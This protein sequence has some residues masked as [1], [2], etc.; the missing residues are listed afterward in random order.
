MALSAGARLGVYEVISLLGVGG[1]GEVYR[2]RDTK[3]HRDVAL[4]ILPTAFT[5]DE[6]RLRRFEQE[7]RTAAGLNHPNICTIYEIGKV[8]ATHFIAMELVEGA[9]LRG[10]LPV[11]GLALKEL[12]RY[13]IQIADGL[14]KAHERGITHRDV[15]PENM[16]FSDDGIIKI[17]DF[18]LA[19]LAESSPAESGEFSTDL[20][21]Q[22]GVLVGTV[23]Y[24]SPEQAQ[25]EP[26]DIRSD[27][28]SLGV[29]LFEF[30][31]G[32]PPYAGH[33]SVD[34]LHAIVHDPIPREELT[35]RSFPD[36]FIRLIEKATEKNRDLRYPSA[37]EIAVDLRRL[38][39]HL[40]TA[41]QIP[42]P[43]KPRRVATYA[44]VAM[45]LIAAGVAAWWVRTRTPPTDVVKPAS[46]E[47]LADTRRLVVLPFENLTRQSTDDWLSGALADSLTFGL[48]SVRS[49]V[50][51]SSGTVAEL[52]RQ[53]SI[54]EAGPLT[55]PVLQ[56]LTS[57]VR[58]RYYVN[59]TYQKVGDQLRV[60]ASLIDTANGTTQAQESVTDTFT[61][62]FNIED[63]LTRRVAT[64]LDPSEK[65]A[66][67]VET[68]SLDAY[69]L[70]SEAR[71]VY[72]ASTRSY[73]EAREK[74]KEVVRL[75][76]QYA[77]GWAL[78]GKV[79][80]RLA[81]PGM[82]TGGALTDL[83][84][85][86]LSAAR[87]AVALNSSLYDAVIAVALASRETGD[88]SGWRQ[89]AE[90]ATRL[91]PRMAEG[92]ALLADSY[93]LN[94][95]WGCRRDLNAVQAEEYYRRTLRIDPRFG[96]AYSNFGFH[97]L[98]ADRPTDALRV[99][100]EGL[101]ILPMYVNL[102]TLRAS[103]LLRLNRVDEAEQVLEP[104]VRLN[105]QS[106]LDVLA[107][108][109]LD[110]HRDHLA[111]ANER[112]NVLLRTRVQANESGLLLAIAAVY[113][114]DG[115]VDDASSLLSRAFTLEPACVRR[116]SQFPRL[117][118]HRDASALAALLKKF[119]Q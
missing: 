36:E 16:L 52:Y 63:E 114:D 62:V 48:Q 10:R 100:E 55:P 103:S 28:F 5:A 19:K 101:S 64:A 32:V 113:L 56:K 12:L 91:N 15:K 77:Q 89:N 17:V 50:L 14:A 98:W 112:L 54:P 93:A 72:A 105:A 59:G 29:T 38:Q 11:R 4:K 58:A 6:D 70:Y 43:Q 40:E 88:S 30:A 68:T 116:V 81:A 7:A 99:A 110:L 49:V 18:G 118:K 33:S 74:L 27:V 95:G 78:L 22:P 24:M 92:Y 71:S 60:V 21:T 107:L 35:K 53:Q 9:T 2:A 83:R 106:P 109:D 23:R 67:A 13:A 20:L 85:E 51:V 47:V 61:N 115:Y 108:I 37:R 3:L 79:D 111:A 75:D 1:M 80:A 39:H 66:A 46:I 8:D 45:L 84:A 97:L 94:A 65:A 42:A 117:A 86:A 76:P 102:R 119:G 57:L 104:I 87:H 96:P 34:V 73:A 26:I 44:V 69:R 41:G 82:F 31:T 90:A 25:R